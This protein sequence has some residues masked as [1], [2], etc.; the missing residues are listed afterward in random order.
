VCVLAVQQITKNRFVSENW[1][2]EKQDSQLRLVALECY[3]AIMRSLAVWSKKVEGHSNA[4]I[5][6]ADAEAE[7][8]ARAEKEPS[9]SSVSVSASVSMATG[10]LGGT[11][12]LMRTP[13]KALNSARSLGSASAAVTER[14][15]ASAAGSGSASVS[16]VL[17]FNSAATASEEKENQK[18]AEGAGGA[19]AGAGEGESPEPADTPSAQ[20]SATPSGAASSAAAVSDTSSI[21][22]SN[23]S[24]V[25]GGAGGL[26]VTTASLLTSNPSSVVSTPTAATAAAGSSS[27]SKPSFPSQFQLQRQAKLRWETGVKK[28]NENHKKGL[29]W[30]FEQGLVKNTPEGVAEFLHSQIRTLD[31]TAVCALTLWGGVFCLCV[32]H[33]KRD[34]CLCACVDLLLT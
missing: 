18:T 32:T 28:F 6:E 10:G 22:S 26:A 11:D 12:S 19:G 16:T 20:P 8:K 21:A 4:Y 33:K 1:M 34:S 7:R 31:K 14:E 5:D 23:D 29:Q 15:V 24:G 2:D 25:G 27:A 13:N 3:A 30:L 9:R 17:S